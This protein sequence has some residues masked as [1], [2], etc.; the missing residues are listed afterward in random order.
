MNSNIKINSIEILNAKC[1]DSVN[2]I[3]VNGLVKTINIKNSSSDSLDADFSTINFEEI[4]VSNSKNDCVDFSG[5]NYQIKKLHV[6]NCGDKGLSV[7]EKSNVNVLNFISE[8]NEIDF[9][10][11]DSSKLYLNKF[12]SN[13]KSN[14]ICGSA[15]NKK[16]EFNGGKII[17]KTKPNCIIDKDEFSRIIFKK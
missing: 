8:S 17:F 12:I 14:E 11:K 3:D 9:V 4:I 7:G 5:G 16:Q 10:S 2:F 1:E 6:K 13:K 15:Y